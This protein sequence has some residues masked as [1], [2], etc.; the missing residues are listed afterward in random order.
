MIYWP[1][2]KSR[3]KKKLYMNK[4]RTNHFTWS[5]SQE[6]KTVLF[7]IPKTGLMCALHMLSCGFSFPFVYSIFYHCYYVDVDIVLNCQSVAIFQNSL[8]THTHFGC[9]IRVYNNF[10]HN[11]LRSTT[12]IYLN[13]KRDKL[14]VWYNDLLVVA[15]N[16]GVTRNIKHLI[17]LH[18]KWKLQVQK[19]NPQVIGGKVQRWSLDSNLHVDR[20]VHIRCKSFESQSRNENN[21]IDIH[22]D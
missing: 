20:I 7:N 6:K 14:S 19:K 12:P 1:K 18:N 4:R 16:L 8:D 17:F 3:A 10:F 2:A 11:F 13:D 15:C 9:Q 21:K 22:N 5:K